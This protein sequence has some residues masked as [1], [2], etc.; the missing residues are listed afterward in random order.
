MQKV[1]KALFPIQRNWL[2]LCYLR[3]SKNI[4]LQHRDKNTNEFKTIIYMCNNSY[5]TNR[6]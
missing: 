5:N 2:T 3:N 1:C 4:P 6:Y